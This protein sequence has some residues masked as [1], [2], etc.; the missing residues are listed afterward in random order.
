MKTILEQQLKEFGDAMLTDES[1]SDATECSQNDDSGTADGKYR[2][3]LMLFRNSCMVI[4][5][6]SKLFSTAIVV[7]ESSGN[8]DVGVPETCGDALVDV[9]PS[10]VPSMISPACT[11]NLDEP[12][13]EEQET[14]EVEKIEDGEADVKLFGVSSTPSS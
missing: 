9:T 12:Y 2:S 5:I 3:L 10:E 13:S 14:E 7:T 11:G 6:L 4:C 8:D 1:D